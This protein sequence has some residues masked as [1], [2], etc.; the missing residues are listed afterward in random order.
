VKKNAM[1]RIVLHAACVGVAGLSEILVRQLPI[2]SCVTSAL[3][4]LEKS[5][6]P[7]ARRIAEFLRLLLPGGSGHCP[8][9]AGAAADRR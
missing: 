6:Y 3:Q 9:T 4:S 7:N 2:I 1:C 8:G 5:D